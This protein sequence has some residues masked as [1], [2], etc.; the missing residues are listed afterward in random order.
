M[1]YCRNCGKQVSSQEDICNNCGFYASDGSKFCHNCGVAISP[2]QAMCVSCHTLLDEKATV[3]K[4]AAPERHENKVYLN[5]TANVKKINTITRFMHIIGI[6]LALSLVFLPIYRCEYD[7][8]LEDITSLEQLQEA[9]E[10][11]GH[12][13]KNFSFF[14]DLSFLFSTVFS[15]DKELDVDRTDLVM[16]NVMSLFEIVNILI[17]VYVCIT[18]FIK[19]SASIEDEKN[20]AKLMYNDLRMNGKPEQNVFKKNVSTVGLFLFA[21]LDIFF[22]KM[23]FDSSSSVMRNMSRLSGVSPFVAV[24]V[25]LTVVYFIAYIMKNKE[26]DIILADINKAKAPRKNK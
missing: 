14:D 9:I 17:Y 24:V 18:G 15:S 12:I 19:C 16:Y 13:E 22:A 20:A 7:V 2:G 26:T 8:K 25:A 11:G 3:T 5:Y 21:G 10:S 4:T 23:R 1:S 6:L